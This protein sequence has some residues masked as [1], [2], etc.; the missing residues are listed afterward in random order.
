MVGSKGEKHIFQWNDGSLKSFSFVNGVQ[1]EH[2][3]CYVHL[4]KRNM[5]VLISSREKFCI[6]P[7]A[8]VDCT[9]DIGKMYV[10]YSD[11]S[12]M[13]KFYINRRIARVK[14][15]VINIKNGALSYRLRKMKFKKNRG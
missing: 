2:E 10:K 15:I 6:V 1:Q 3:W 13:K 4:Q 12:F 14:E 5:K 8:F 9:R 11:I 7:N